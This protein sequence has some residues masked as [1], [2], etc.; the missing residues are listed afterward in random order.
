[1]TSQTWNNSSGLKLCPVCNRQMKA[2]FS[3]CYACNMTQKAALAVQKSPPPIASLN[4]PEYQ[5]LAAAVEEIQALHRLGLE[6]EEIQRR[7]VTTCVA[8][9]HDGSAWSIET[10]MAQIAKMPREVEA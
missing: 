2:S 9:N 10:I 6:P 8:L 1:M 4:I 7:T 3:V 5:S